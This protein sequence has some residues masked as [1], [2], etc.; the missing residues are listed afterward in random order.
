MQ[1]ALLDHPVQTVARGVAA[2]RR[3]IGEGPETLV[4]HLD[5]AYNLARWLVHDPADAED[6]VQD[7]YVRAID[8]YESLQGGDGRGW[9]L[10]IVR[11]ACYDRLRRRRAAPQSLNLDDSGVNR[12]HTSHDPEGLILQAERGELLEKALTQL[13][14]KYREAVVLREF[15]QLSYREMSDV[16]GIPVGTVMSRLN[17][18]R[19]RLHRILVMSTTE[20]SD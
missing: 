11:N 16:T 4:R 1:Q 13:P 19:R 14:T 18:A 7:A 5:S 9:L 10:A 3:R 2:D 6:A 15:E 8:H 20:V 17:R 12:C